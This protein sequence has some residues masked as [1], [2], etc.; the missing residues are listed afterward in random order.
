MPRSDTQRLDLLKRT[1]DRIDDALF[2]SATAADVVSYTCQDGRTVSRS[3][4]QAQGDL[5][6]IEKRIQKL[7]LRQNGSAR[8][9]RLITE[10]IRVAFRQVNE[11][12]GNRRSNETHLS[13]TDPEARLYCKGPGKPSKLAQVGYLLTENRNGLIMEIEIAAAN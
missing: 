7:E 13:R 9:W 10:L 1:R 12:D 4:I 8:R 2:D 5:D 6:A 3:R 11:L